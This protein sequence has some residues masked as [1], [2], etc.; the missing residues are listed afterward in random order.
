M[1]IQNFE[2]HGGRNQ[3]GRGAGRT[4]VPLIHR[5]DGKNRG[6]QTTGHQDVLERKARRSALCWLGKRL[7]PDSCVTL[8]LAARKRQNNGGFEKTITRT[9]GFTVEAVR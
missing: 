5:S 1:N 4:G 2:T 8:K 6:E 9:S 3:W 7:L